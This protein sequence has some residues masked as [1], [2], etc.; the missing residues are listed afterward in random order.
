MFDA[1]VHHCFLTR[2]AFTFDLK[3]LV[4]Q[5]KKTKEFKGI[6][7]LQVILYYSLHFNNDSLLFFLQYLR[8]NNTMG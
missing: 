2:L 8:Q 1:V 4:G 7:L 6:S 3:H 5:S